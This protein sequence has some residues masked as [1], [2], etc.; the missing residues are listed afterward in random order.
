MGTADSDIEGQARLAALRKGLEAF[1]WSEGRNIRIDVRWAAGDDA[2]RIH[3]A[4]LVALRPDVIVANGT[5][6][7]TVLQQ[8]TQTV[9]VVFTIVTDPVGQEL[10][11]S[12]AHPGGNITGF[13]NFEFSMGGKWLGILKGMVPGLERVVVPFHP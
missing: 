3:A 2:T 9:P 11:K 10:V 7:A 4:E 1:G 5:P 6:A 12:L 8:Q 13:T